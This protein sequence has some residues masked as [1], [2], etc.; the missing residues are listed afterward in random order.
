MRVLLIAPHP[1]FQ[2]RGTPL[3]EFALLSE[4]SRAGHE[5]HVAT[6]HEGEDIDVP[7]CHLHRIPRLPLVRNIRPGLSW[8]KLV[9]DAALTGKVLRLARTLDID[10]V[11]AVEEGAFMALAVKRLFG[12]PYIYD[13]DSAL[14]P[15]ASD[16]W[17]VLHVLDRPMRWLER[18]IVRESL[19]VLAVCRLLEERARELVP[20]TAT[21]LLEDVSL[22]PPGSGAPAERLSETIGSSGP[23]VLYVGNLE[24]YQGVDLLL[25]G[26]AEATKQLTDA[27][28][29]VI[30]GRPE[31]VSRYA[32]EAQDLAIGERTHFLGP[33]PQKRLREYLEQ[34]AVLVSPRSTGIN[35]PMKVYSYLDSGRPVAATRLPTHT[36]VL[37]DDISALFEPTAIGMSE[38]LVRLLKDPDYGDRMA[39]R[40]KK[41]VAAEFSPEAFR[42]KLLQFYEEVGRQLEAGSEPAAVPSIGPDHDR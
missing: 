2:E 5:I 9:A 26:F 31:H 30:G 1:F 19:F 25:A 29:V 21:A 4:L 18:A 42:R 7:R 14:M 23:I 41:R 36:Q 34:A 11:H 27:Q 35:T 22:L 3:A 32:R 6:Y 28:L 17:P 39:S 33:R 10:V 20:E 40:A 8:K 15:Q 12:T 13:M 38:A 37:D 16:K 24:K